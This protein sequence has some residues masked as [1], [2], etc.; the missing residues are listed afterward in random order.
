[1]SLRRYVTSV[2]RPLESQLYGLSEKLASK[3]LNIS[4]ED[5]DFK[6]LA[7]IRKNEKVIM[8]TFTKLSVYADSYKLVLN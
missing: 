1:M 3:P 4:Q 8:S 7:V 5:F 2:N 6:N